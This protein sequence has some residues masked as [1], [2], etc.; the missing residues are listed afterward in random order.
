[1]NLELARQ[2]ISSRNT[3]QSL[4]AL[5]ALGEAGALSDLPAVMNAVKQGA[6]EKQKAALDACLNIIR[7]NLIAHFNELDPQMRQKLGRLMESLHPRV[8]LEISRDIYSDDDQRRLRAV[9]VL[10]L[11]RKNP[12][13]RDILADLVKD[14][15]QKIRA[16]AINLL[17]KVVGPHDQDIILSLLSDSDK[18][19][20]ANTVEALESLGNKR[21]VPVLLR[22][23]KDPN[24]RIRGNVL[25]ALY[26]LG[27]QDV[28]A[29]L[30]EMLTSSEPF[31]MASALWVISQ[32]R[33]SSPALEDQVGHALIHDNAMVI[34]NARKALKALDSPRAHGYLRYLGDVAPCA[35]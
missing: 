16:T 22:F 19:V 28:G 13:V 5:R 1:M 15:D 23:R 20:R 17:G 30:L 26:T 35:A 18:R 27:Y 33:I 32:T 11:L 8:V 9:Q 7:E 10:G 29:D 6:P 4:A 31:M 3:E 14:R 24:N 2:N 34:D 25:K 21:L 12:K